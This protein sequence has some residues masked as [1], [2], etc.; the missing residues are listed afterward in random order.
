MLASLF[1]LLGLSSLTER[2]SHRGT[3]ALPP[4]PHA[5]YLLDHLWMLLHD[6][7]KAV[8]LL[9]QGRCPLLGAT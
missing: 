7:Q 4:S 6:M 5:P 8:T 3:P 2:F 9:V 1:I